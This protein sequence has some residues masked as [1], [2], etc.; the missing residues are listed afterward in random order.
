MIHSTRSGRGGDNVDQQLDP[1]KME[2][3]KSM[4][5]W[6]EGQERMQMTLVRSKCLVSI[7]KQCQ[8]LRNKDKIRYLLKHWLNSQN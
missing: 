4:P 2:H 7:G 5:Q 3:I 1:D 8:Q 6:L